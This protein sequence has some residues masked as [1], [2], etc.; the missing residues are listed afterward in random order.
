M[1]LPDE[2]DDACIDLASGVDHILLENREGVRVS[3][4]GVAVD[5]IATAASDH[6]PIFADVDFG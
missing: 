5:E 4:Y 6:Y 2:N 3:V 1:V